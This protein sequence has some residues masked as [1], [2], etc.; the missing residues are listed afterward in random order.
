MSGKFRPWHQHIDEKGRTVRSKR[1]TC[2]RRLEIDERFFREWVSL[3]FDA[4][5]AY[6]RNHAAFERYCRE[7]VGD[8]PGRR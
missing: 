3:G 6:L 1:S 2:Q 4:L 8:R 7:H 5:E